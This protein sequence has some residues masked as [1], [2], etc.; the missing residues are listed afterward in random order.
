MDKKLVEVQ[1]KF[2]Y[3]AKADVGKNVGG[4]KKGGEYLKWL[5]NKQIVNID[6]KEVKTGVKNNR[7]RINQFY[8]LLE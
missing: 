6:C 5:G 3:S 8:T 4:G 7:T 1:K 2:M